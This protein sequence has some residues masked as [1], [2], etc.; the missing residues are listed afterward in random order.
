M[1]V[2]GF[3]LLASIVYTFIWGVKAVSWPDFAVEIKGTGNG[4]AVTPDPAVQ[5]HL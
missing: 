2:D 4:A 1:R 3:L 5:I